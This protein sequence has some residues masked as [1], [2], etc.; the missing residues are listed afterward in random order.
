M[1][2]ILL[3]ALATGCSKQYFYLNKVRANPKKSSFNLRVINL[4]PDK[5]DP[6]FEEKIKEAAIKKM[7]RKG[8]AYNNKNPRIELTL[9]VKIDSAVT[10]GIAFLS[11][12]A[13]SGSSKYGEPYYYHYT[14]SAKGVYLNLTAQ[15]RATPIWDMDYDLYYFDE[16]R[17]D[18]RRTKGV[19]KY[20]VGCFDKD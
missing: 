3:L 8:H 13:G 6:N 11:G 4:S 9:T 18:L 1:V 20:M 5:I 15:N 19:V 14:R 2:F 12:P 10:S 16:R 17:R 7:I